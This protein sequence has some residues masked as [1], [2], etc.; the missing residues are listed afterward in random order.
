MI[1]SLVHMPADGLKFEHQ[2][3]AGELETGDFSFEMQQPVL[4][5][6]RVERAGPDMRLRGQIKASIS[7][8]CDRCL[9][10]VTISIDSP[11]DLL[12]TPEDPGENKAGEF[13]LQTRDLDFALY[14]NDEINLD[15]LVLE[16]L[17]LS[18]PSRVLCTQDCLGL[19]PQCGVDLNVE[20]CNCRQQV[21]PRWHALADLK[22]KAEKE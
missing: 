22:E 9:K 1:I 3:R 12:Y 8:P 14:S 20:K 11:F 7:A 16:Q 18:L 10:Q 19:C 4:V 21:D 13:E 17:E 5:S 15:D 6:G 2:Y